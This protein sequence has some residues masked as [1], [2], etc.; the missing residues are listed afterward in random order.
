MWDRDKKTARET[1]VRQKK[2][3]GFIYVPGSKFR[4]AEGHFMM[5]SC[6]QDTVINYTPRIRNYINKIEL[7]KQYNPRR[8]KD[9]F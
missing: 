7:Y 9:F 2:R 3:T 1:F 4:E 8:V 6:L 5:R